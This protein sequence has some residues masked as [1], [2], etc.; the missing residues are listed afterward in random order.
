LQKFYF[1][2]MYKTFFILSCLILLGTSCIHN[3]IRYI[4]DDKEALGKITEYPNVP[5]DY[6]IKKKDILYIRVLSSNDEVNKLFNL[7]MSSAGNQSSSQG[8]SQFYLS[9]YTVNDSGNIILPI[10]GVINV[11]GKTMNEIRE[12]LT[13][14]VNERI[15]NA[16][17]MVSL[18]SFYLT[19]VGE[20]N[21]QGKISVMQDNVNILQAISLAGG[22]S[23]Y[24][25]KKRILILRKTKEGS[26][27][28]RV[29][30]TKRSL[31]LSDNFFLKPD[32]ILIA[33]P[34]KNKSFQLGAR[35]YSLVLST[36]T[37][38]VAMVLLVI[39]L[40]K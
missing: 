40:L 1:F 27:T 14:R 25:N 19:F 10:V 18:V 38:T 5:V 24:G 28:F 33:E 36:V 31:L 29:D 12:I 9:G 39:N 4:I 21:S 11:E 32:D 35:D 13:S 7:V 23:D 26:E 34:L 2:N 6:T 15:N 17:V 20:F 37:S 22:I 8:A 3:K 30:L 16:D